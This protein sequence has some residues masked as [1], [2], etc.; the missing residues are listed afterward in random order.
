MSGQKQKE[1]ETLHLG[2]RPT[3]THPTP[4]PP[5]RAGIYYVIVLVLIHLVVRLF[6]FQLRTALAYT[7]RMYTPFVTHTHTP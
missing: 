4:R 3:T 6:S 2:L 7:I 5:S 1:K